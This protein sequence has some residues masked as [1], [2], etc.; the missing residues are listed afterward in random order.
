MLYNNVQA[1]DDENF[2]HEFD[3]LMMLDHMNIIRLVGYCYETRRQHTEVEGKRVFGERTYKALCF[4]YMHMGSLQRHLSDERTGLDWQTRYKIIKGTCV[5]LKYLHEG[6]KEPIYHLDLKP[7]NILLDKNMMPKLADFGLSKLFG[8]EQTRVTQ[9]SI[10]I[11]GYLPPEYLFRNVI[12][13]K[14]D[15]FS[16]GVIITKIITGPKGHTRSAEIS[17][18][19]FLNQ[20]NENWRNRLEETCIPH[21]L[22]ANCEQLS[23]CTD[24]GLRCMDMDRHKRP[25]IVDIIHVLDVTETMIE[26]VLALNHHVYAS[27]L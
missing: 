6:L 13:K 26:K 22:E 18:Q 5:G 1:V 12:S 9:T 4:E 2:V 17:S 15:I 16:L 27:C 11:I 25:S 24:I 21:T 7:D 20:V 19:E 14:L 10:G 3:N 8:E 23:I